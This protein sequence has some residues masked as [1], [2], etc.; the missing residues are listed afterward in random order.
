MN[1]TEDIMKYQEIKPMQYTN[2]KE[3]QAIERDRRNNSLK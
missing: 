2:K 3:C 1:K